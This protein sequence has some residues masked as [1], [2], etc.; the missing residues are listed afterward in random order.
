MEKERMSADVRGGVSVLK[1]PSRNFSAKEQDS[2]V[3]RG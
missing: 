1:K 2:T 3:V